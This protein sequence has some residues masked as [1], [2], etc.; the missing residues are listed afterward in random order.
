MA[1]QKEINAQVQ[2]GMAK[3][4][5]MMGAMNSSIEALSKDTPPAITEVPVEVVPVVKAKATK[6]KATKA[7]DAKSDQRGPD[8]TR[9]LT[10]DELAIMPA[11]F[12]AN[13]IR[14]TEN[15]TFTASYSEVEISDNCIC[16]T[17]KRAFDEAS[18]YTLKRL[19]KDAIKGLWSTTLL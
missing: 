12:E 4:M 17:C 7:K 19:T 13:R 11:L 15:P 10:A 6:A 18:M 8:S 3:L 14:V 5:E 16:G 9:P 2:D 1:S